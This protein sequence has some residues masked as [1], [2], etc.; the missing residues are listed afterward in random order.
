MHYRDDT[1]VYYS[2]TLSCVFKVLQGFLF[3]VMEENT[4][5]Q[6]AAETDVDYLIFNR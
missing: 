2:K 5:Q 6:A 3:A 1:I 4:W